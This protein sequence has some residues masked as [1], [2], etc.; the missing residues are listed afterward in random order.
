MQP[1][2]PPLRFV[3][4]GRRVDRPRDI[5]KN[6]RRAT[7]GP[8]NRDFWA[9][10]PVPQGLKVPLYLVRGGS[11]VRSRRWNDGPEHPGAM[12]VRALPVFMPPSTTIAVPVTHSASSLARKVAIAA[13]SSGLPAR[14]I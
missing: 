8:L 1:A 7:I 12:L 2:Q 11:L 10:L 3:G 9:I 6:R 5:L 4:R 14:G 13:I